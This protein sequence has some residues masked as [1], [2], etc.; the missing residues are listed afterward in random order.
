[1]FI[2]AVIGVNPVTYKNSLNVTFEDPGFPDN[3][4]IEGTV[5]NY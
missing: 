5:G 3:V 4:K 2:F 1:M